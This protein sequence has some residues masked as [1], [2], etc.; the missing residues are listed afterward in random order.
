MG[1]LTLQSLEPEKLVKTDLT[2][3]KREMVVTER[4]QMCQKK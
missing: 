1:M 4:M 3:I 2:N